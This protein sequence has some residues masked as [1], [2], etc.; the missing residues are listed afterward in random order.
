MR[1]EIHI[2]D[3]TDCKFGFIIKTDKKN[4]DEVAGK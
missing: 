1:Y 4:G 3:R 2:F